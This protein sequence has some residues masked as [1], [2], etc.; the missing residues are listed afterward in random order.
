MPLWPPSEPFLRM[1]S[2]PTRKG[3][4][5]KDNADTV[6]RNFVKFRCFLHRLPAVIHISLGF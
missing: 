2:R 4:I 1:R 6:R 5:V 3:D